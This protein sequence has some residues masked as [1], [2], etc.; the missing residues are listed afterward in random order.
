MFL[1]TEAANIVTSSIS[2][3][4]EAATAVDGCNLNKPGGWG[5][6][7]AACWTSDAC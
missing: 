3:R 7:G 2:L 6:G 5:G 1:R 4:A